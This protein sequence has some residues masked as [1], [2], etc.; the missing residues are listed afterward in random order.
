MKR[1]IFPVLIILCFLTNSL[2]GWWDW[3]YAYGERRWYYIMQA[4]CWLPMIASILFFDKKDRLHRGVIRVF[5]ECIIFIN[6][7]DELFG[8]PVKLGWNEPVA[9]LLIILGECF[10]KKAWVWIHSKIHK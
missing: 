8:N 1:Y 2:P 7:Y 4:L 10:G 6:L 5:A 3:G 9:A